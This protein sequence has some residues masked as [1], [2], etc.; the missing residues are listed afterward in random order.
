[1]LIPKK[2]FIVKGK[3]QHKDKLLS[4]EMALRDAGIEKFNLVPVS[5]IF[6]PNCKLITKEEG[7]KELKPGQIVFCVMA[8]KTSNEKGK[9]IFASIGLSLPKN[10]ELNG[11]IV[12]YSGYCDKNFDFME[13]SK[14]MAEEITKSAFNS[15]IEKVIV[16]GI[17]TKVKDY[18]TVI[19]A[20]IFI[21]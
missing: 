5:S 7:L 16:E 1:M 21:V 3:G 11:Y 12:E 10:K 4:F 20:V 17:K 6:P 13:H 2:A 18:T 19:T 8:K 14:K 15:E 9:E